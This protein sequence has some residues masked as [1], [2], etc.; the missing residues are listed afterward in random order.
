MAWSLGWT[1][2]ARS[3]SR[4]DIPSIQGSLIGFINREGETSAYLGPINRPQSLQVLKRPESDI[5]IQD[6]TRVELDWE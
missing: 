5:I 4:G 2:S 3:I 1:I 6:T